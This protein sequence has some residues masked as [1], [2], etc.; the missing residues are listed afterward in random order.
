MRRA[1]TTRQLLGGLTHDGFLARHWQREPLF[2]K[3]AIDPAELAL[4]VDILRDWSKRDDVESRLVHRRGRRWGLEQ[5]P[6]DSW[7]TTPRDWTV[8]I[9]GANLLD[10]AVDRLLDRFRW[11]PHARID[12]IMISH[13][14][15]GGGVGPH[16]DSYDVFLVQG[17]GTRRW[18]VGPVAE[19]EWVADAPLKLLANFEADAE[20]L[21][22]PGDLLYVPPGWGHDGVALEPCTTWSVGFRAPSNQE[23]VGEFLTTLSDD[24]QID[25]RYGDPGLKAP[26]EPARV[27]DAMVDALATALAQVRWTR[28]DLAAF[29]GEY[30][31]DPKA[32]TMFRPATRRIGPSAFKAQALRH[33]IALDAATRM[34]YDRQRVFVNGQPFDASDEDRR[35]LRALADRR[36]ADPVD[37]ADCPTPTLAALHDWYLSGWIHLGNRSSER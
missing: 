36:R 21:C 2:V 5:G 15:T 27:P 19:P 6:L 9:Q 32:T 29:M 30:L 25:G 35:F 22:E 7:P 14:A 33:G 31:S 34:L 11:L 20:Y 23:L 18:R 13:A 12:D 26:R 8:L 10:P 16:L 28:D 3:A 4:D 1:S 24:L 37:I 17:F